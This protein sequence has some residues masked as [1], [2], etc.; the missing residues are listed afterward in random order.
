MG[1]G[2]R[3]RDEDIINEVMIKLK[4]YNKLGN[5]S[6]ELQCES[7]E[8]YEAIRSQIIIGD[9]RVRDLGN[10]YIMFIKI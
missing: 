10:K 2:N 9:W 1:N 3:K 8:V 7:K 4:Y 6:V 5:E